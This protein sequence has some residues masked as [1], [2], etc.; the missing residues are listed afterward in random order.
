MRRS[1]SA[2]CPAG[3][4]S[5][6]SIAACTPYAVRIQKMPRQSAKASTALPSA[7]REDRRGAHHQRSAVT[8]STCR[9]VALGEIAHHR[10]RDHHAGRR[11]DRGDALGTRTATGSMAPARSQAGERID[12]GRDDQRPLAAEPVGQC[13]LAELAH[14]EPGEPGG[15]RQLRRTRRAR[16]TRPRSPGRP[17]GTCRSRP[18]RPRSGSR[19]AWGARRDSG[20]PPVR[21]PRRGCP[22]PIRHGSIARRPRNWVSNRHFVR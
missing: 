12:R 17:A 14:R 9:G 7:G 10:A 19:A 5:T 13:A 3:R 21:S 1:C 15:E 2:A 18:A 4:A 20:L 22:S 6:T 16:R 8:C 11:A